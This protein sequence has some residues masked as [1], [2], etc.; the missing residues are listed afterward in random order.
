MDNPLQKD[1]WLLIDAAGPATV[2]GLVAKGEWQ[3]Y[4]VLEVEFIEGLQAGLEE[5]L[6]SSG[7]TLAQL[8]G[9]IYA[10]GPG[11]TLG[12][13]LAAMLL[14]S[15]MELPDLR[16]W[17]CFQ[18]HNLSLAL[19]SLPE[20]VL[21]K[22][23]AAVAP[24]RRDRLHHTVKEPGMPAR[25]HHDGIAPEQAAAMNLPG[26]LL[27]RRPRNAAAGIEWNPYPHEQ[28]PG[29]LWNFPELL[30]PTQSPTPYAAEEPEF[31]RW[32]P[33]RHSAI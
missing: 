4:R 23:L 11:S 16:R 32:T 24:W 26:I 22:R 31:A 2:V 33:Q 18:Y 1:C 9:C 3:R 14:R 10:T 19:T 8:K 6:D 17:K 21:N 20:S 12:L 5:I 29:I 30:E 25:Y 13:R 27:G 15:F 28:V 7:K